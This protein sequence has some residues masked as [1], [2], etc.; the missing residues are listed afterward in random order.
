MTP[1]RFLRRCEQ[2]DTVTR[3]G[4]VQRVLPTSIEANGP[5]VSIGALCHV[6][7][8][9]AEDATAV[10]QFMAEV[11]RID[12]DHIILVPME[13]GHVTF[14]GAS[15]IASGNSG[16]VPVGEAYIGQ[17][18]DALGQPL[19][20]GVTISADAMRPLLAPGIAPLSRSSVAL[21]MPTG[22]RVIDG[23]LPLGI[24]Q[25]VGIFA[26]SGVG[27]TSLITQMANQVEAD[28]VVLCVVG[29]RGREAEN[30]WSSLLH[31]D[32]R[33]RT[34]LIVATSDESAAM[35]VRAA[36]VA[37]AHAEYHRDQGRH[38]LFILDS[39]TRL[40]MALREMGLA[41][42]EPPTVRAYTP[43]VFAALPR[44]VER[45]GALKSSG[46]I[47]GLLTIL[48]ETDDTE[49]PIAELLKSL[50]DGHIILTRTLAEQGHYPAIDVP[51]SISRFA[52]SLMDKKQTALAQRAIAQLSIYE[53]SK[54]LVEAGLYVAGSNDMLDQ[55]L[56]T[57]PRLLEFLKQSADQPV[58]LAACLNAL[59]ASVGAAS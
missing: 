43:G 58:T 44:F 35:R 20:S 54:T 23:L 51:R 14:S 32:V 46:A 31:P 13:T 50:L 48:C 38:V 28:I 34:T 47:T 41:A 30:L 42:G 2:L 10:K 25:R 22:L 9:V 16:A 19:D 39:M 6:E 36:N 59:Q 26:A 45:C 3:R 55:A 5:N 21:L 49:D 40:A 56:Q 7:A 27:K 33:A 17:A 24:G 53:A 52:P 18:I 1:H 15:V 12:R 29:E 11:V 8:R 37:M 4:Q 57:R